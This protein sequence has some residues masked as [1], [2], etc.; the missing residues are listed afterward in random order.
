MVQGNSVPHLGTNGKVTNSQTP[1]TRAKR[2]PLAGDYKQTCKQPQVTKEVPPWKSSR[3]SGNSSRPVL[4]LGRV[5]GSLQ[6]IQGTVPDRYLGLG[7]VTGSLQGIQGTVPDRYLELGRVTGSLQG[8]QGT[9]PDRYLELGRVT[10]SL[11]GIQGTV[12]DRYLEGR[13]TESLQGI[14]GTVHGT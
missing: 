3:D 10:G 1:Q 11:Q 8:I 14:Q 6:G 7:R 4:R 13:V 5:T 9:V 2:S 12:P